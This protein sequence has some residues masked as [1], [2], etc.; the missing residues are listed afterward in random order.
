MRTSGSSS[1]EWVIRA[2]E[3]FGRAIAGARHARGMTQEHLA[4]ESGM[5]RVYLAR[6]ESGGIS[7]LVLERVLRALRRSGAT[8]TV[9]LEAPD[10]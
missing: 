3:D 1:K 10:A 7:P 8:V 4:E 6:L 5:G 2:P 9:T